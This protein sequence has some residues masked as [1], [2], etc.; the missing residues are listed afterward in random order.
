MTLV[1]LP[2]V[3]AAV[4][5]TLAVAQ[6]LQ[7]PRTAPTADTLSVRDAGP[8]GDRASALQIARNAANSTLRVKP[9]TVVVCRNSTDSASGIQVPVVISR[10]E[11]L[12]V[13]AAVRQRIADAEAMKLA[14]GQRQ[15]CPARRKGS[16]RRPPHPAKTR[17]PRLMR[18][19]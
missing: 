15:R 11:S 7:E 19:W 8:G 13:T 16:R 6:Q 3:L 4:A 9:E 14:P 2:G 12:T 18:R 1:Y 10:A 17:T 5:V